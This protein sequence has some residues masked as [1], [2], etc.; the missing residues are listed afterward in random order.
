[1]SEARRSAYVERRC[2]FIRKQ[3]VTAWEGHWIGGRM[4]KAARVYK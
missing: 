4:E 1:M 3:N 2:L